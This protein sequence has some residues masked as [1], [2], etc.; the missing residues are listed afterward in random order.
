MKLGKNILFIPESVGNFKTLGYS[1]EGAAI[2]TLITFFLSG[3]LVRIWA[4][5]IT[6][7][8]PYKGLLVHYIAAFLSAFIVLTIS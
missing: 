1:G 6:K 8:I 3:I 4:Y 7:V 2:S 5:R